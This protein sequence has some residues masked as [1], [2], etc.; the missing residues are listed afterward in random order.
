[1][2]TEAFGMV[3]PDGSR[4]NPDMAAVSDWARTDEETQQR[5][6]RRAINAVPHERTRLIHGTPEA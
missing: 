3:A 5:N 4:T 6:A 1:M 2:I